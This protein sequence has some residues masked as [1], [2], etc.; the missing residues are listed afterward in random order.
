[1]V[2][3]KLV[4]GCRKSRGRDRWEGGN[5]KGIGRNPAVVRCVSY[6]DGDD[7]CC[8]IKPSQIVYLNTCSLCQ[9]SFKKAVKK[10]E[11]FYFY[12]LTCPCLWNKRQLYIEGLLNSGLDSHE[13]V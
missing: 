2:K 11:K 4:S 3:R 8:L 9:S 6:L 7:V 13:R 1:M 5:T 12:L 10:C